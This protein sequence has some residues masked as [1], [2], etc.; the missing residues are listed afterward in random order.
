MNIINMYN[1]IYECGNKVKKNNIFEKEPQNL[2]NKL[3]ITSS[4]DNWGMNDI[5]EVFKSYE[6]DKEYI[7]SPNSED[8]NL[9]IFM[10]LDNKKIKSL[11]GHQDSITVVRYFINN[12]DFNEYLI[13]SDCNYIVIIWDIIDNYNIK[14]KIE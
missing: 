2:K 1:Q 14:H 11:K 12:K 10:L 13:S 7:I 5:F 9:D 4:N 6:D 8:H 3:D